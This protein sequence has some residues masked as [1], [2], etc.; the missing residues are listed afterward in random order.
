M[1]KLLLATLAV[2]LRLAAPLAQGDAP[3]DETRFALRD[4]LLRVINRDRAQFGLRP[5]KLD[6][7]ASALADDY[8]RQQIKNGTT[9]HFTLDGLAPYMRYSLA[10]GNDGVSENVAAWSA[11]YG[12]GDRALYDMMR[13]S[14]SAMMGEAEPHDG[15]RKTILDPFATHVGIGLAWERGEFRIAEEFIRRYVEWARPLP[16]NASTTDRAMLRVQPHA[17]YV[18]EAITV[19]HESFPRAMSAKLA[20]DI[21]SYSLPQKRREYLP[22][23]H[24]RV[25]ETAAY[26]REYHESYADGRKGDFD[27]APDGSVAFAIPFPDGPGVY[28]IVV[29]VHA[30]GGREAIAASNVSVR[31]SENT[32]VGGTR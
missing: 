3:G 19:H 17:G 25:E 27:V 18:V 16:R 5:V 9:G 30:R 12:F 2:F 10:G 26:R 29:W 24:D 23:L 21:A 4:E 11:N 14:Q 31:V 20:N 6:P 8:C 1:K 28:T 13:K 7:V 15:H 22:R 32:V